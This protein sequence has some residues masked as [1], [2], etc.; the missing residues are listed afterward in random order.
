MFSGDDCDDRFYLNG[1]LRSERQDWWSL[2]VWTPFELK[3]SSTS[4]PP[5]HIKWGIVGAGSL[6]A[7]R[8]KQDIIIHHNIFLRLTFSASFFLLIRRRRRRLH[9]RLYFRLCMCKR[10]LKTICVNYGMMFFEMTRPLSSSRRTRRRTKR[11]QQ[12]NRDMCQ[13]LRGIL[14]SLGASGE[15]EEHK[16]KDRSIEEVRERRPGKIPST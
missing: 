12:I 9:G 7:G 6:T 5:R 4:Q 15:E 13:R 1:G 10:T 11:F 16:L 14:S 8:S 2:V 3:S